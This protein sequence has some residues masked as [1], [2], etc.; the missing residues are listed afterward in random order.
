MSTQTTRP[1]LLCR[2]RNL[3]D[4]A[5]WREFVALYGPIA[6]RLARKMGLDRDDA[7]MI[8]QQFLLRAVEQLHGSFGYDPTRGRFR[9]WVFV[10]AYREI[11]QYLRKQRA[12]PRE[13]P[14]TADRHDEHPADPDAQLWWENAER[15]RLCHA[16]LDQLSANGGGDARQAAILRALVLDERPVREVAAEFG[17]TAYQLHGLKFR[18]LQRLRPM[19]AQLMEAWQ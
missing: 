5:A 6:Y 11:L 3:G 2:L 7:D 10:V 13:V 19:L 9:G 8:T 14:I 16:A 17:V 1:T 18:A 4:E 15:A 12:S